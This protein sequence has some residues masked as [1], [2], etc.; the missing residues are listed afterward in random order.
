MIDLVIAK[1][2]VEAYF[3]KEAKLT[4]RKAYYEKL[5]KQPWCTLEYYPPR[6]KYEYER[7]RD[8]SKQKYGI[9]KFP[10]IATCGDETYRRIKIHGQ[11]NIY[12]SFFIIYTEIISL[13]SIG[14]LFFIWS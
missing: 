12:S 8:L 5:L 1:Y 9:R 14:G 3:E 10:P 11:V 13:I 7:I 2:M 4:K 6:E